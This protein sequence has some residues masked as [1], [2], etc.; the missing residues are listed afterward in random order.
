M[1]SAANWCA[2]GRAYHSELSPVWTVPQPDGSTKPD[3]NA[4]RPRNRKLRL[5]AESAVASGCSVM[6]F[7]YGEENPGDLLEEM[8]VKAGAAPLKSSRFYR[9]PSAIAE[10]PAEQLAAESEAI[11]AQAQAQSISVDVA[12]ELQTA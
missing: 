12:S 2:R 5:M 3:P 11:E 9:D 4:R 10:V 7:A 1:P 8:L 6:V